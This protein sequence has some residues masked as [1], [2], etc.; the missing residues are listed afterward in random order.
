[1]SV[2]FEIAELMN[3]EG[4]MYDWASKVTYN[5]SL[6]TEETEISSVVDA[7]AKEIGTKGSDPN[8]EIAGYITKIIA[9]EVYDKPD[10]LLDAMFE[11][12]SIGEFDDYVLNETPKNTLVAYDAAKGGNVDKS[13][14]DNAVFTPTWKHKQVETSVP[15][16]ALRQNG[17][18][19]IANLTMFAEETLHNSMIA[20]VFSILDTAISGGTQVF[21]I[22]G[23]TLDQ[24]SIDKL[25]LYVI[26][27]VMSGDEPFTFSLSK[28]AQQIAKISGY[29]AFMSDS[30]KEDYNKY[31]LVNFYGGMKIA[32]ISEAKRAADNSLLVPDK[33]IFGVA[34]K[35]GTLD[36]RGEIRV[37]ET[38]DNNKEKVDLKITGFEF[39]TAISRPEKVGK[40]T[41]T[42]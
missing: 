41:F 13:Y 30:M 33:V 29:T 17:F 7:W 22:T 9:P 31:G 39:G 23:S 27:R 24:T 11:R 4:Q 6:T 40:I 32:G 35:I 25:S 37:L 8:L 42:A 34:G 3:K 28:Y 1:M 5:R 2:K 21:G 20:D 18:K 15:Y 14:I 16:A 38:M 26:D 12:G 10:A 36:M 19:S